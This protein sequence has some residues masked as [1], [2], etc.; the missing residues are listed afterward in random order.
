ME[1]RAAADAP[2]NSLESAQDP[3]VPSSAP[4]YRSH[5]SLCVPLAILL[6]LGAAVCLC[7]MTITVSRGT[8][9]QQH[10]I[11]LS[12]HTRPREA[13]RNHRAGG[14]ADSAR[15]HSDG[16]EGLSSS[17]SSSSSKTGKQL[18]YINYITS[19]AYACAALQLIDRLVNRLNTDT[20]RIDVVWLHTRAVPARL[21]VKAQQQMGVRTIQVD[22]LH[23]TAPDRTWKDSLTKLRAFQ[24]WGYDR[25]VF[26][27]SDA[28]PMQNLDHLFDLPSAPLYAPT[29]YWIQQPFFASTLL[30]IESSS[31]VFDKILAWA[32]AR[33]SAAGFDMDILNAFFADSVVHLPGEYTVLNSDFRQPATAQNKLFDTV[34][35][36]KQHTKVVHF[37]CKPDGS[38]GKP[39]QWPSH[40]L[41]LLDDQGFD[42]LFGELFEEYWRGEKQLCGA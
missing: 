37:S 36:L 4:S 42:P 5:H 33:G 27:D 35:E 26:L 28:V 30:V 11:A 40:S 8:E 24:D 19:D 23:A 20:S 29:A 22:V 41:A 32:R 39:W 14:S 12:N 21:L 13:L 2:L 6:V 25:V 18:A 17:S 34:H 10:A 1:R 31:E 7:T 38:Y 15:I 3:D 16:H 9:E